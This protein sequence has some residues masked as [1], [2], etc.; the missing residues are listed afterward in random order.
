MDAYELIALLVTAVG[1]V[2]F[3]TLFTVLYRSYA[4]SAAT[5]YESGVCDVELIEETI[6]ENFKNSKRIRRVMKPGSFN[7]RMRKDLPTNGFREISL[8]KK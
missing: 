1:V 8:T 4:N 5:E 3:G 6:A 7:P 2:S